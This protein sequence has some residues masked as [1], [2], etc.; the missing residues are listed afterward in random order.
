M[1][2]PTVNQDTANKDIIQYFL[3]PT[4]SGAFPFRHG[5]LC[6]VVLCVKW[7]EDQVRVGKGRESD[8]SILRNVSFRMG[9]PKKEN[10]LGWDGGSIKNQ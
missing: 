5:I 1:H 4:L 7:R 9:H 10:V 6:S 3:H 2:S 8:I